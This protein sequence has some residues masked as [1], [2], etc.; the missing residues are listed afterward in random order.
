MRLGETIRDSRDLFLQVRL[1]KYADSSVLGE[2][3]GTGGLEKV[4]LDESA[5]F[6]RRMTILLNAPERNYSMPK[7]R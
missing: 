3:Q 2:N 5:H 7:P 6:V 4:I 1:T